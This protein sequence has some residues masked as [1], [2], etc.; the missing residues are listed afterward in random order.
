[1]FL[2]TYE[3]PNLLISQDYQS[4]YLIAIFIAILYH[5]G[6]NSSF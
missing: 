2:A 4:A 6:I 3:I 5:S 1:M